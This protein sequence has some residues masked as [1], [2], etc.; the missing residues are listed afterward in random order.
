[1]SNEKPTPS[2]PPR[3][4]RYREIWVGVFVV[5]GIL[6]TLILLATMTNAALFRGRYIVL[7]TLPNAGGIR[8]GDPVQIRGVNVG[9][10]LSFKIAR[11]SVELRL[12]IEGEYTF[13]KDSRV[14]LRSSGLLGG[15]MAEVIPGASGERATWGD[16]LPG[17]VGPGMFDKV[18]EL[19]GEADKVAKK[20]QSLLSDDTVQDIKGTAT[21]ARTSLDELQQILKEQRSNLR[22]LTTSLRNTTANLD[23]AT[24][25]PELERAVKRM[26]DLTA[27]MDTTLATLDRSSKSLETVLGRMDRGEGTLGKL[28]KDDALYDNALEATKNLSKS[29]AELQKLM[30]D[31]QANPKKYINLKIF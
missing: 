18:D 7:T 28:S 23:K 3:R 17:A 12:E 20:L 27:R 19:S 5:A 1:V 16:R 8:K 15:M 9:R 13:P 21:H 11:D 29:S 22:E 31:L 10:I 24:S 4:G 14:E 30:A 26:D 25:G 6:A 2:A